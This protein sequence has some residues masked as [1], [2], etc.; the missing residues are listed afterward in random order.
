MAGSGGVEL[1]V[2]VAQAG[3][4]GSLPAA[5]LSSAQLAEH[6][7]AFRRATD[8]PLNVNFFC[9]QP[10]DVAPSELATWIARLSRFDVELGVD[11][12]TAPAGPPR[13][14][15]DDEACRLVEQ[16]R[17]Q[18]VSFH[19]G[20][21]A[22]EL[23]ERVRRTGALVLSSA[24]TQAEAVWLEQHGCDMVIAQGAEAGGHRGMF[25]TTDVASQVGTMA[26]VPRVFDA[27]GVPVIAAG[28]LADGRG[29]A[30][31]FVLGAAAVQVGTAYLL[32]PEAL[33]TPV[34]RVAL[35]GGSADD[36]VITNVLTG[37]PARGRRNRVIDELG[38]IADDAPAFPTAGAALAPL[39]AAAEAAGSGDFSL[40]WSGQA[41][42]TRG[43][44]PAGQLT[45]DLI[46]D[47]RRL[48]GE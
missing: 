22:P 29:I 28:G 23:V 35:A 13:R 45:R 25:L 21:P 3:G 5:M 9:H 1:A 4:L 30:A 6:I 26:L 47:A 44:V 12:S 41:G 18:I 46:A 20:L 24:T 16:H 48:L 36:T 37:R 31:A 11:R 2:A 42:V 40:L 17:P 8:A 19:F 39:R 27:V 15:F 34:H 33:T 10:P 7:E 32:S 14:P 43:D 38:P